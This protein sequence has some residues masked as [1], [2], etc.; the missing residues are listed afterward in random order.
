[1]K[2]ATF[3]V[4]LFFM[5]KCG[6]SQTP[7]SHMP[8][9]II[10]SSSQDPSWPVSNI[11]N[12][13]LCSYGGTGTFGGW[14]KM[15][16]GSNYTINTLR[17]WVEMTPSGNISS[18]LI[19]VSS[20]DINWTLAA[21]TSGPHT[22]HEERFIHF[23]TPI[24]NVRYI[25]FTQSGSPSWFAIGE[26]IVNNAYFKDN[27]YNNMPPKILDVDGNVTSN[28][29]SP[30]PCTLFCSKATTYQWKKTEFLFR[31]LYL[32]VT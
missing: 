1:M 18:E 29:Y 10:T 16:L 24:P 3:L 26:L 9:V 25:R 12:N 28:I 6:N 13:N 11:N 5:F 4:I 15:D 32:K 22:Q 19:E 31:G 7:I 27:I 14:I 30:L 23:P 2:K 8:G 17:W 21:N 20:D